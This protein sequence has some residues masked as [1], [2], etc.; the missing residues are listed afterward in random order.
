M[1]HEADDGAAKEAHECCKE[2]AGKKYSTE[3][4]TDLEVAGLSS[5][6]SNT[7]PISYETYG[8]LSDDSDEANEIIAGGRH[9]VLRNDSDEG[10][11]KI[12]NESRDA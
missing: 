1:D 3:A 12:A 2:R 6:S 8:M 7:A 5:A 9:D 11:A 10:S 4:V